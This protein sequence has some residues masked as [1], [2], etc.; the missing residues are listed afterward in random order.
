[1]GGWFTVNTSYLRRIWCHADPSTDTIDH[2][3]CTN[4]MPE[5]LSFVCAGIRI[6][7]VVRQRVMAYSQTNSLV[8]SAID[9]RGIRCERHPDTEPIIVARRPAIRIL[10]YTPKENDDAVPSASHLIVDPQPISDAELISRDFLHTS[11]L[12]L[13]GA[14]VCRAARASRA[15]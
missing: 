12:G 8:R 5:G 4:S 6:C 9:F 3:D 15:S 7:E 2:V 14:S 13:K 10:S 11:V 1:M